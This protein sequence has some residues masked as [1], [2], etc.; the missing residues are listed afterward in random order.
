M[1][2]HQQM[3]HGEDTSPTKWEFKIL[4]RFTSSF[5]RQL[6]ECIHIRMIQKEG[7]LVLNKKEEYSRSILPQLEVSL[8]GKLL[9]KQVSKQVVSEL[10]SQ[11]QSHIEIE[12]TKT[13]KRKDI[14]KD[15][16][17]NPKRYKQS[18]NKTS[19]TVGS[20]TIGPVSKIDDTNLLANKWPVN[21]TH[22]PN[23]AE[24]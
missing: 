4:R 22:T 13:N 23:V 20:S 2:I 5:Y 10:A 16:L 11:V 14:A 7:V 6:S 18:D 8:R 9:N 3:E 1:F 15:E 24:N 12:Q 21:L 17:R 19:L